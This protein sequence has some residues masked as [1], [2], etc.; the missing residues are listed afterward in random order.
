MIYYVPVLYLDVQ[1]M[2]AYGLICTKIP[3]VEER[4]TIFVAIK[5]FATRTILVKCVTLIKLVT[6]K[7]LKNDLRPASGC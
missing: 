4:I 7:I 6:Q 3:H 2:G 5:A 1:Y